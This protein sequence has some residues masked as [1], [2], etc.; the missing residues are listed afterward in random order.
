MRRFVSHFEKWGLWRRTPAHGDA[1]NDDKSLV[2]E[3][4]DES[5]SFEQL[6]FSP[7]SDLA[8]WSS[9][10]TA[11]LNSSSSRACTKI[12]NIIEQKQY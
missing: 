7:Q 9:V 8:E 5:L 1:M 4:E 2:S 6:E 10:L 11:K 3:Y 12:G